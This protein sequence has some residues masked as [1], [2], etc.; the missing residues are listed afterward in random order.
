MVIIFP[1]NLFETSFSPSLS[2]P[3]VA[4]HDS[5]QDQNKGVSVPS[6]N[7]KKRTQS[8][9]KIHLATLIASN[10]IERWPANSINH[11]IIKEDPGDQYLQHITETKTIRSHKH[12]NYQ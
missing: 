5:M 8:T 6:I 2:V 9:R 7:L 1:K 3:V 4:P 11:M 12:H 10:E